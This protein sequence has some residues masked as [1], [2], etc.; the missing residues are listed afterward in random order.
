VKEYFENRINK[1]CVNMSSG[2]TIKVG[3]PTTML[4][5]SITLNVNDIYTPQIFQ[6]IHQIRNAEIPHSAMIDAP[7][8][9]SRIV[10]VVE[11]SSL[12]EANP[13]TIL[14]M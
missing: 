2:A 4:V 3:I 9:V 10:I 13:T 11:S 1:F 14:K 6:G 8:S 12:S 7:F 5:Q